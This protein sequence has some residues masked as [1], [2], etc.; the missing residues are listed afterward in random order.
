MTDKN[1]ELLRAQVIE[2]ICSDTELKLSER[3]RDRIRALATAPQD[4]TSNIHAAIENE[5]RLVLQLEPE[6][7]E[8]CKNFSDGVL[9]LIDATSNAEGRSVDEYLK[10]VESGYVFKVRG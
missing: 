10:K 4:A 9:R 5:L 2:R 8:I 3:Q 1:A 7:Y 6:S